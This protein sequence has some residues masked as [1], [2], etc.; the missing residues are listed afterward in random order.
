MRLDR[1]VV[2]SFGIVSLYSLLTQRDNMIKSLESRKSEL[3]AQLARILNHQANAK[4]EARREVNSDKGRSLIDL[5]TW[6]SS[7]LSDDSMFDLA[8]TG[9]SVTPIPLPP[10]CKGL[11][12]STRLDRHLPNP[13]IRGNHAMGKVQAL[14]IPGPRNR[15]RGLRLVL[16]RLPDARTLTMN[17]Q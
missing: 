3:E 13:K 10:F 1:S 2:L 11:I 8:H 7:Q 5:D 14:L 15:A 12:S 6:S 9:D 17:F 16:H 4:A